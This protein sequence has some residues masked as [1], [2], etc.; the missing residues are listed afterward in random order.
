MAA[1]VQVEL[2]AAWARVASVEM[3]GEKVGLGYT[4]KA[5]YGL[6]GNDG[7]HSHKWLSIQD[8]WWDLG[9][10]FGSLTL[11]SSRAISSSPSE[12]WCVLLCC[13]ASLPLELGATVPSSIIFLHILEAVCYIG[14]SLSTWYYFDRAIQVAFNL[15]HGLEIRVVERAMSVSSV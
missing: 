4:S 8:R 10:F 1:T 11:S 5:G 2:L 15:S 3:Q 6:L 9:T 14:V 13:S 7:G 12:S